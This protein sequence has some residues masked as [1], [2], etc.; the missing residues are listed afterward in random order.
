MNILLFDTHNSV[1]GIRE[2][3]KTKDD[4]NNY[5]RI[6]VEDLRIHENEEEL[7]IELSRERQA[8]R[9]FFIRYNRMFHEYHMI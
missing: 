6:Q 8:K 9:L 2:Y 1:N 7:P 4:S 5:I 3:C